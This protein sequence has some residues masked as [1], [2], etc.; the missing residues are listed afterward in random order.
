MQD[1]LNTKQIHAPFRFFIPKE[2]VE[3][4]S[5]RIRTEDPAESAGFV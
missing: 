5:I 2:F 3:N 1:Y 4:I